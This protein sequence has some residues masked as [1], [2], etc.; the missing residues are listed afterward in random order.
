MLKTK[1]AILNKTNNDLIIDDIF[2]DDNLEYGQVL[3]KIFYSGI[4]GSQIGEIEAI[5]GKDKYLPHLLGHEGSGIVLKIGKGV[6]KVKVKDHVILHWKKT[7][8][9]ESPLPKYQWKNKKLNAGK[10]TTLNKISIIS[11][12]RITKIDKNYDLKKAALFGCAIT[13]GF[14][15]ITNTA[16]AKIGQSIL[17]LGC[18]GVGLSAVIAA[19]LTSCYPIIAV[20]INNKKLS[21]AK[22][23]GASH[24]INVTKRNIKKTLNNQKIDYVVECTGIKKNVE[25]AY[26]LTKDSGKTVLVGVINHKQKPSIDMMPLYFNKIITGSHGGDGD[27]GIDILNYI[28]ILNVKK[29]NIKNIITSEYKFKDINKAIKNLRSGKC[30]GRTLISML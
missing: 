19:K 24:I 7:S 4:C 29:I 5:K 22:K 15:A 6:T 27:P 20:D 30:I 16:K 13:T 10:I 1:G 9:I 17:I 28:N 12:N 21:L 23:F 11:E 2:V 26:E 14:G 25:L 8:G 3:V 18:G